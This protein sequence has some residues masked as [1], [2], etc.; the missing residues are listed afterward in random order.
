MAR[1]LC[2]GIDSIQSMV[3]FVCYCC[4]ASTSS[5]VNNI[6]IDIFNARRNNTIKEH[7]TYASFIV[8]KQTNKKKYFGTKTGWKCLCCH[9]QIFPTFCMYQSSH[10]IFFLWWIF[11]PS[12]STPMN[13]MKIWRVC[14]CVWFHVVCSDFLWFL[15]ATSRFH[16]NSYYFVYLWIS[17]LLTLSSFNED[18]VGRRSQCV[19]TYFCT[20]MMLGVRVC[21]FVTLGWTKVKPKKKA[22]KWKEG[23]KR[24]LPLGCF[25]ATEN[26]CWQ[27]YR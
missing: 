6:A 17:F 13:T 15:Y 21:L 23:H 1:W 16:R 22:K 24:K 9:S 25:N 18:S 20:W 2:F 12:L 4:M 11:F 7:R 3:G 27:S 19:F 26:H 8:Q 5:S 10:F 14:V